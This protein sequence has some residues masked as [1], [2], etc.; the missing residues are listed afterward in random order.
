MKGRI[1]VLGAGLS[2]VAAALELAEAGCDVDLY[3]RCPEPFSRASLVSE[4]KIHLGYVYA[5]DRSLETARTMIRGAATFKPL[6]ARWTGEE[7]FAANAST[8]FIYAVPRDSM[9]SPD[10]IRNH[11]SAV[12]GLVEAAPDT[13]CVDAEKRG[14]RELAAGDVGAYFDPDVI[15]TAFQTDEIAIDTNR[16]A[17]ILRAALGSMDRLTM[18]L[19]N[20]VVSVA[21]EQGGFRVEAD[22]P[23]GR[24]SGLYAAVVN[25]LWERRLPVDIELGM[26]VQRPAIHRYKVGLRTNDPE[27]SAGLPSVTFLV[28]PYGD[29]TAFPTSA[30]VSWYPTGLLSQEVGIAP[31]HFDIEL[32]EKEAEAQIAATLA[33]LRRFMPGASGALQEKAGR[34]KVNGGF[35]SAWGKSGIEDEGSE[36]HQRYAVGVHSKGNYHSIDTGKLTLA[37]LFAAEAAARILGR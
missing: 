20:E 21:E 15:E 22:G 4:G 1:A 7:F 11:F 34:W 3:D 17:G 9:M 23:E 24:S 16:L 27:V 14:W 26:E 6:L 35:I 19:S 36:L 30:F 8:P 12:A 10:E 2:G 25:A 37:P 13:I 18:R 31:R 33:G 29:S 28:G 5:L 32:D